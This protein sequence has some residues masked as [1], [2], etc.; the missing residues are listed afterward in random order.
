[1]SLPI[2]TM[3]CKSRRNFA[4]NKC[5]PMRRNTRVRSAREAQ[6][7]INIWRLHAKGDIKIYCKTIHKDVMMWKEKLDGLRHNPIFLLSII[8]RSSRL[9]AQVF[10]SRHMHRS[11]YMP[12][13]A[14][15]PLTLLCR[16]RCLSRF[17]FRVCSKHLYT[18][19]SF[20]APDFEIRTTFGWAFLFLAGRKFFNKSCHS[21]EMSLAS[22]IALLVA[23]IVLE[24]LLLIV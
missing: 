17:V 18:P 1:M 2:V 22:F 14:L 19:F 8:S 7:K 5:E 11:A 3:G 6:L 23:E 4:M 16:G 20:I 13:A 21:C 15:N 9:Q 12:K 24:K 10:R